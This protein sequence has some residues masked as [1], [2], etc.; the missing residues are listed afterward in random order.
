MCCMVYG[1][2]CTVYD[3]LVH[4]SSYKLCGVRVWCMVHGVWWVGYGTLLHGELGMVY[5]M[6]CKMY[7]AL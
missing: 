6:L 5:A 7:C 1:A 3:V 2:L 4:G